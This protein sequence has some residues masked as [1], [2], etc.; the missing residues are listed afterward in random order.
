MIDL[1][2][3]LECTYNLPWCTEAARH[4]RERSRVRTGAF[5][6]A[7]P[8]TVAMRRRAVPKDRGNGMISRR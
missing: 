3:D 5:R 7:V 4:V 1:L 8:A 2:R 6:D